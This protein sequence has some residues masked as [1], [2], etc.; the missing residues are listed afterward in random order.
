MNTE[1]YN[2]LPFKNKQLCYGYG[3]SEAGSDHCFFGYTNKRDVNNRTYLTF[4]HEYIINQGTATGTVFM[5][6]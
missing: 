3:N 5:G 6:S 1:L 2:N 4:N